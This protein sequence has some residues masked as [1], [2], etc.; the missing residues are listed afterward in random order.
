MVIILSS[1]ANKWRVYTT[2]WTRTISVNQFR[3]WKHIDP[4]SAHRYPY[5]P[6]TNSIVR[7]APWTICNQRKR[8][9]GWKV[10][11]MI[12]SAYLPRVVGF[13]SHESTEY[14]GRYWIASQQPCNIRQPPATW[15]MSPWESTLSFELMSDAWKRRFLPWSRHFVACRRP[16]TSCIWV[17]SDYLAVNMPVYQKIITSMSCGSTFQ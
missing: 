10:W 16:H 13:A 11:E 6:R 3:P 5:I 4:T 2:I 8:L 17:H 12:G 9:G 7:V 1:W 15:K 14:C